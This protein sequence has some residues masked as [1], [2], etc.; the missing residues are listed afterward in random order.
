MNVGISMS[1]RS[2]STRSLDTAGVG[3]R[4][5]ISVLAAGRGGGA[6]LSRWMVG[7]VFLCAVLWKGL[8]SPDFLDARFFR[9]TL[10]T[11]ERFADLSRAIGGLNQAQLDGN[12]EALVA[13][14]QGAEV[15]GGP[16]LF[17]PLALRR[18]G[19]ALTWGGFVMESL[20]ALA[21]LS[22]WPGVLHRARHLLLTAFATV[23]YAAAP[24]AGFG[25]LLT[26]MGLA[27]CSSSQPSLRFAYLGAFTLVL[28]YSETPLVH[29]VLTGSG[30]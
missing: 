11:D 28:I 1:L 22:G 26:A 12:R 19:L 5:P 13:L 2:C 23:T 6:V 27:Q 17:E 29:F 10:V 9:L 25:W 18:L 8:L 30:L 14:P 15:V 20:L 21:F 24:I 3:R 4:A 16:V 7:A